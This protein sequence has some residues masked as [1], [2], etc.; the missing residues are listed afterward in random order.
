M[1]IL[2]IILTIE[3]VGNSHKPKDFDKGDGVSFL[4]SQLS[5]NMVNGPNLI[6]GDTLSDIPMVQASMEYT[7]DTWAVFVTDDID[8]K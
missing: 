6:C 1:V 7:D 5:L 2:F 3:Q 4:N 8:L